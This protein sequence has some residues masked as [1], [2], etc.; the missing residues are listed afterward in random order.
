M[1]LRTPQRFSPASD[2]RASRKALTMA[3]HRHRTFEMFDT[4]S[5][6]A[7]S[8]ES[9]S[10]RI[11][12][13]QSHETGEGWT[14]QCLTASR[15]ARVIQVIFKSSHRS[16][17]DKA[18]DLRADFATLADSLVNDSRVLMDFEGLEVFCARSVDELA[19]F[20]R[21]LQSKGSRIALCNL[22]P[23]VRASFFPNRA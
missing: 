9:K 19:L 8:F 12:V 7:R 2:S 3:K 15:D 14:L 11:V 23:A 13:Q 5:E 17:Q 1:R 16:E 18:R 22:G 20:R 4:Y 6:A 10:S 21:K